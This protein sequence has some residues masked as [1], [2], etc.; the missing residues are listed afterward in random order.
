[1]GGMYIELFAASLVLAAPFWIPVAFIAYAA[2]RKQCSLKF[3]FALLA[4]EP[5]AIAAA[6]YACS[7]LWDTFLMPRQF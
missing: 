1:M 3:M 5:T 7:W 6:A 4:I 2:G